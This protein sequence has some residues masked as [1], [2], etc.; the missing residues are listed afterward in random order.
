MAATAQNTN[1]TTIRSEGKLAHLERP[2]I[3]F[4][5]LVA[6]QAARDAYNALYDVQNEVACLMLEVD[7]K[8]KKKLRAA[9]GKDMGRIS[10]L[11]SQAPRS[12]YRLKRDIPATDLSD[13]HCKEV[14][15]WRRNCSFLSI[16]SCVKKRRIAS[17]ASTI[18]TAGT[19]E[20]WCFKP[21]HGMECVQ[22]LKLLGVVLI[23][24][25][26][27]NGYI[28]TFTNYGISVSKDNVFY[29]N[30]I[31][32]D[33]IYEIDMHNLYP[34]VS[35]MFNVSNKRAKHALD[36]SYLWHCRLGHI[37]KKCM[38]K[39]QRDGILQPTHDE[40][41]GN[42]NDFSVHGYVYLKIKH[43]E[44]RHH[45]IR[46]S[47]KKKLIQIIKIHTY[48]NVADLLTKAFDVSRFQYLVASIGMLNL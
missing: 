24:C 15:H 38:D 28:H 19:V 45:F 37:N 5:Y 29:F 44:I 41:L 34:N 13:H 21:V 36:S 39:L 6:S 12:H 31:P 23:F 10:L 20:T 3:P 33:G 16:P 35:S 40:S 9:K 43:I 22:P 47:N 18:R 48:Q 42:A 4:P 14:G 27:N 1:N 11:C 2:L 30:A 8:D 26:V 17:A 46:N 32:R 25:L 7:P